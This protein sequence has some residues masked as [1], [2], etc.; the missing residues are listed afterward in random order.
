[1]QSGAMGG[2]VV[3][4][5][6]ALPFDEA[7]F[8][9]D[10]SGQNAQQA[11]FAAAIGAGDEHKAAG[12]DAKADIAKNRATAAAAGKIVDL[13]HSAVLAFYFRAW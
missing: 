8:Y 1:M 3:L 2:G 6:C 11:G 10:Q 9:F 7:C 13:E 5:I 12:F 4:N